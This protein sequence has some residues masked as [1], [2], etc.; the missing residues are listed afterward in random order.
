VCGVPPCSRV[1][2]RAGCRAAAFQKDESI[3]GGIGAN[4]QLLVV[5]APPDATQPYLAS[6]IGNNRSIQG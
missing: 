5:A 6:L 4:G 2:A 3:I 1:C